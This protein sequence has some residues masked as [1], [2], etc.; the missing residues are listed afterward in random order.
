MKT[1]RSKKVAAI[2]MVAMLTMMTA[3]QAGASLVPRPLPH[4]SRYNESGDV[5][6]SG[7]WIGLDSIFRMVL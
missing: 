3:G 2:L 1:L 7:L 5:P 6:W 4:P